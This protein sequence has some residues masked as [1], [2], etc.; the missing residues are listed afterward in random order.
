M[1]SMRRAKKLAQI[2]V[3]LVLM[4]ATICQTAFAAENSTQASLYLDNYGAIMSAGA[5]GTGIIYIDYEVTATRISD[6][7]GISKIE[8]YLSDDTY[9]TTIDGTVKN[10]LLIE[11]ELVHAGTYTF[12]GISGKYYYAVLT[13]YAERNGGSDSK[14][15]TTKTIKAP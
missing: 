14:L 15:Y 6:K 8:F 3:C 1:M 13:M 9:V 2:F 10:K 4:A 12:T 7:V 11:D 5:R